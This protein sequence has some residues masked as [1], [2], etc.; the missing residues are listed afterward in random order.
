M[1]DH[2]V[3]PDQLGILQDQTWRMH[4]GVCEFI[5]QMVYEGNLK[6]HP[7][8]AHRIIKT[9]GQTGHLGDREAGILFSPVEHHGNI[10]ASDEEVERIVELTG[11]LLACQHTGVD[12]SLQ[13]HLQIE[14]I[15]YVAPYNMQVR[16]LRDRLPE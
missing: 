7:R 3:V 12:Q 10:Q 15:L 11:K 13:G 2:A 14:D 16:K 8:T 1:R 6:S 9:P 5:S 4:P